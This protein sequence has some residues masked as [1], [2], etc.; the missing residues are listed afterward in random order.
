M[1][2]KL[3]KQESMSVKELWEIQSQQ[4]IIVQILK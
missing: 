1:K 2:N 4:K 3:V